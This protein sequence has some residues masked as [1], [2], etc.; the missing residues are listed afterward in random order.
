MIKSLNISVLF[1]FSGLKLDADLTLSKFKGT[2]SLWETTFEM[3]TLMR[4]TLVLFVLLP[5]STFAQK[6]KVEGSSIF[7]TPIDQQ[8]SI[9]KVTFLPSADN[10]SGIYAKPLEEHLR[11]LVDEEK[12]WAVVDYK[13]GKEKDLTPESLEEDNKKAGDLIK[14]QGVDGIFTMRVTRGPGGVTIRLNLYSGATGVW[15]SQESLSEFQGFETEELKKQVSS[16]YKRLRRKMPYQGMILSRT[17]NEVTVNLGTKMGLKIDDELTVVQVFK[18]NRHPKFKFAIS[19]EKE[20]LGTLKV[21]KSEETLSFARIVTERDNGVLL[22]GMKVLTKDFVIYPEQRREDPEE[23]SNEPKEPLEEKPTFGRLSILGGLGTF[24]YNTDL[25]TSGSLNKTSSFVPSVSFWGELWV[26]PQWIIEARIRQSVLTMSNPMSGSKPS[27]LNVSLG[28]Y[29]VH[30]GYN[31]LLKNEFFGPKFQLLFGMGS[32]RT[33]VDSSTPIGL[34]STNQG[35]VSLGLRGSYPL[36]DSSPYAAGA[37][38]FFY[39]SPSLAESP[40]RSGSARNPSINQFGAFLEYKVKERMRFKGLLGFEMVTANFRG[41]SD[42]D[43]DAESISQRLT[44][45]SGGVEFLF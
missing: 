33:F 11:K 41:N 23:A 19:A 38:L 43:E 40:G 44:L 32:Q 20:I 5:F 31:L 45:L 18:I 16:L 30:F 24:T 27:N 3:T 9:Q 1:G 10:I 34:T 8:I 15:L 21:T 39:L 36:S 2:I 14:A 28:S 26:T 29:S 42:A 35:G 25:E 22:P 37:E 12:Q 7:I 17:A 6:Q 13:P 4:L